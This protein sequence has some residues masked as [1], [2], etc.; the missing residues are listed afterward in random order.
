MGVGWKENEQGLFAAW[1]QEAKTE[2]PGWWG[3]VDSFAVEAGGV[4]KRVE[5]ESLRRDRNMGDAF[6][7]GLGVS[8]GCLSGTEP[9]AQDS[10]GITASGRRLSMIWAEMDVGLGEQKW[11]PNRMESES[12]EGPGWMGRRNWE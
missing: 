5:R 11:S 12:G 3:D 8:Q 2:K 7:R 10:E 9:T 6:E 4:F 1:I